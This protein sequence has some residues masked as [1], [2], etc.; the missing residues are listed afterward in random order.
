MSSSN[1]QNR[2]LFWIELYTGL[3]K[4]SLLKNLGSPQNSLRVKFLIF[5]KPLFAFSMWFKSQLES[6]I[7]VTNSINGK[8]LCDFKDRSGTFNT[9]NVNIPGVGEISAFRGRGGEEK[10]TDVIGLIK[11]AV[12]HWRVTKKRVLPVS[13]LHKWR[14]SN[15]E[16]KNNLPSCPDPRQVNSYN[17]W[18]DSTD[19]IFHPTYSGPILLNNENQPQKPT[20]QPTRRIFNNERG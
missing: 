9:K 3:L 6:S 19:G 15:P 4:Q 11:L 17:R 8:W 12:N 2:I 10:T 1:I 20:S 18:S 5:S 13:T 16:V 7:K 14:Q